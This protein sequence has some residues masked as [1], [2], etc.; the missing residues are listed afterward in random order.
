MLV[1]EKVKTVSQS[2]CKDINFKQGHT[3]LLALS[4]TEYLTGTLNM[5]PTTSQASEDLDQTSETSKCSILKNINYL[6]PQIQAI[7][8]LKYK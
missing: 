3:T 8:I 7:K 1:L 5:H 2:N 6:C 4:Q